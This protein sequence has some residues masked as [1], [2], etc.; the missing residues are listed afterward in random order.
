LNDPRIS[1]LDNLTDQQKKVLEYI[2]KNPNSTY[3]DISSQLG[4]K[5]QE[6]SAMIAKIKQKLSLN[7]M[8]KTKAFGEIARIYSVY[9][10][11]I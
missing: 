7:R 3:D 1:Q 11:I 8:Q 2:A 4:I 9:K 10:K 5:K 6:I